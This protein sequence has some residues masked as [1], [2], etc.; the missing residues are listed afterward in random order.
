[1]AQFM[2]AMNIN[3]SAK[4]EHRGS[5]AHEVSHSLEAF[6]ENHVKVDQLFATLGRYDYIALF[7]ADEQSIAFK[8][9]TQINAK[10]ILETETWPVIPYDSYSQLMG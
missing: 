6:S 7:E 5:L 3:P 1:M 8:I 9:A 2:M 4:K 10:G